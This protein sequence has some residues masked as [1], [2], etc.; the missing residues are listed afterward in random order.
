MPMPDSLAVIENLEYRAV[1]LLA[2]Y[3][4]PDDRATVEKSLDAL[5]IA[6]G[7]L[8]ASNPSLL[9]KLGREPAERDRPNA[10]NPD[11]LLGSNGVDE[12]VFRAPGELHGLSIFTCRGQIN[13]PD[14][15]II[16]INGA[17]ED[18]ASELKGR[19]CKEMRQVDRCG[20]SVDGT[21]LTQMFERAALEPIGS[22]DLFKGLAARALAASAAPSEMRVEALDGPQPA[23]TFAGSLAAFRKKYFGEE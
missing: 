18:L 22:S 23:A 13:I 9:R 6:K 19:N 12:R 2:G 15:G 21:D 17:H 10:K 8:L 1:A 16:H 5:R 4:R 7:R 11:S 14:H 20:K 3:L